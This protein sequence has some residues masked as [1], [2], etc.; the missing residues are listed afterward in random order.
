M[1]FKN[2]LNVGY[3]NGY[4]RRLCV[5][6]SGCIAIRAIPPRLSSDIIA[7]L[8]LSRFFEY[9][10]SIGRRCLIAA[11]EDTGTLRARNKENWIQ[12]RM[13]YIFRLLF[14]FFPSSSSSLRKRHRFGQRVRIFHGPRR[15]KNSIESLSRKECGRAEREIKYRSAS[16]F[17]CALPV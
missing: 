2:Q 5:C 11:S 1:K 3:V 4:V 9:I 6:T 17:G 8:S 15:E 12:F 16:F 7:R 13:G 10:P 14:M